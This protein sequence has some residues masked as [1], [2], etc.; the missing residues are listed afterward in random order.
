MLLGAGLA[1]SMQRAK[2]KTHLSCTAVT[3]KDELEGGHVAA[4][5]GHGCGL[6]WW[7]MCDVMRKIWSRQNVSGSESSAK[8]WQGSKRTH[9]FSREWGRERRVE[10][11]GNEEVVLKI[12]MLAAGGQG[13]LA[14]RCHFP[15]LVGRFSSATSVG[16]VTGRGSPLGTGQVGLSS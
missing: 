6:L 2:A 7:G 4:C 1:I 8:N 14:G 16:L 13:S 5:F 12:W 10:W 15:S 9:L 3:D 11:R